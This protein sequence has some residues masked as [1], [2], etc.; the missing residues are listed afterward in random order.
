LLEEASFPMK[1]SLTVLFMIATASVAASTASAGPIISTPS[2]LNAGDHF[3][4][5]F[6]TTDTMSAASTPIVF[7]DQFVTTQADGATYYGN[8]IAWQAIVS[9]PSINAI[10]HIGTTAD[11]AIYLVDGTKV[12]N[13]D[14]TAA[15]GLWSG[16]LLHAIDEDINQNTPDIDNTRVWTGTDASGAGVSGHTV[17]SSAVTRGFFSSSGSA[18]VTGNTSRQSISGHLYGISEELT[19]LAAAVPEPSTAMLAGLGGIAIAI[20]AFRRRTIVATIV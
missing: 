18:W 5:V 20:R 19:V 1:R 9:S 7:Y 2:G 6:V 10:D 12:A 8:T 13:S 11:A 15:H 16:L 14:T 3:R 4:I 17:G